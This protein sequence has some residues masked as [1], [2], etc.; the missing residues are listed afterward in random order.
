[1]TFTT[2]LSFVFGNLLG[3]R[4]RRALPVVMENLRKMAE[5]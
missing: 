3:R 1:V 4:Y 5:G 2:P